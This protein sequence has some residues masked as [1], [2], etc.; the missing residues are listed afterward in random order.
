MAKDAWGE[1]GF[2]Q[3]WDAV[4]AARDNPD[5]ANQLDLLITL[6]EGVGTE[7][8]WILDLGA[9]SGQVEALILERIPH[10]RVACL[11]S[12]EEMLKLA[13]ERL[14]AYAGRYQ[15]VPR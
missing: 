10:A 8:G 14:C 6:L 12:S 3:N 7:D 5:R 11:D 4:N 15:P 1:E 13:S 2:V 9:G